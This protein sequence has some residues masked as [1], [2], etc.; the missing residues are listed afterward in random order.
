LLL[1]CNSIQFFITLQPISA[2]PQYLIFIRQPLNLITIPLVLPTLTSLFL[3]HC[4]WSALRSMFKISIV[5]FSSWNRYSL[6]HSLSVGLRTILWRHRLAELGPSSNSIC[7]TYRNIQYDFIIYLSLINGLVVRFISAT[8]VQFI[9]KPALFN[10]LC[11]FFPLIRFLRHKF[12]YL[13]EFLTKLHFSSYSCI[14]C[15]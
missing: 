13:L 8:F 4:N 2:R 7:F 1:H 10:K 12:Y 14:S 5:S 15:Y 3:F 6:A 11:Y 9:S